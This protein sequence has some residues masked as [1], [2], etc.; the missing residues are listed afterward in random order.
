MADLVRGRFVSD[1]IER[2]LSGGRAV[3]VGPSVADFNLHFRDG[4]LE[5]RVRHLE[6][7]KFEP[8]F[9]PGEAA[10]LLQARI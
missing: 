1:G 8:V 5:R 6:G 3:R 9:G 4:D 7:S 2:P 10:F